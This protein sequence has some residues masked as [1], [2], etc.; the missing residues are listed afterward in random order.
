MYVYYHI[1]KHLTPDTT[2]CCLVDI[3]NEATEIGI[4]RDNILRHTSHV[5][6]GAFTLAREI[7]AMTDLPKEEA[8]AFLRGGSAFVLQKLTA[9]KQ[10]ELKAIVSAYQDKVAD[11]FKQTG[12]TLSIPK[13]IYLHRDA[14]SEPFFLE[15]ISAAATK[16]TGM[17]HTLQPIT[18]ELLGGTNTTN[19][20][21]M[22]LSSAYFHQQI[23]QI[24][25]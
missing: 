13:T 23:H 8:Y 18:T 10:A 15:H 5:P 7:A 9:S 24:K 3:T 12:D 1:L 22:L 4:V 20:T 19:D 16:A 21:A 6:Y 17:K 2:D 25:D 14:D 11:L